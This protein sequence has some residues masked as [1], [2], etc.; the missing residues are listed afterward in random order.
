MKI[1]IKTPRN[2]RNYGVFYIKI[3]LTFTP[4]YYKHIPKPPIY[5]AKS[6]FVVLQ[7]YCNLTFAYRLFGF[8]NMFCT[9]IHRLPIR[10]NHEKAA[11]SGGFSF[12][13]TALTNY[14]ACLAYQNLLALCL[15][16]FCYF[17]RCFS[18]LRCSRCCSLRNS[19]PCWWSLPVF[20]FRNPE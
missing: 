20:L 5:W 1:S 11:L 9:I 4:K 17:R 14:P 8:W 6:R 19:A 13:T 2:F 7:V 3:F 10:C 18:L 16:F 15:L 12:M